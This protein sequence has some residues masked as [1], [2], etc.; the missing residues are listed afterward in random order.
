MWTPS[1]ISEQNLVE[2]YQLLEIYLAEDYVY[3]NTVK[4]VKVNANWAHLTFNI[5]NYQEQC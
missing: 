1:S 4:H 3:Q 2:N 5:L